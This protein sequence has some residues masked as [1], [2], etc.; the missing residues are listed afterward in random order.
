MKKLLGTLLKTVI[1]LGIGV[2][3]LW[4]FFESMSAE[5]IEQFK[6]TMN[7]INYF[8]IIISLVLGWVALISRAQRWKYV[9]EPLGHSTPLW[10]RY[11]AISIGYL[12]NLTI[13]RSGEASRSAMLMRSD[14]VPFSKSFGTIV[15]ERAVDLVVLGGITLFTIYIGGADFTEIWNEMIAKFQGSDAPQDASSFPWKYLVLALVGIGAVFMLYKIQKSPEFKQKFVDFAKGIWAGLMAIFKSK[16]P[17]GY[18][19]H[20]AIIWSCYVL[21]VYFPFLSLESTA[22]LPLKAIMITFFVGTIG[23]LVTNG[24]IGIYPLMVGVVIGYY[25][26]ADF[27]E[28]AAGIGN[29]LGLIIWSCQTLMIVVLGIL[30][31]FL[32]PKKYTK[33][34]VDPV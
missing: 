2:Y 16:S 30:S 10:N 34:N 3:L 11:H 21:M 7:E 23:I 1:P 25:L 33:G 6:Q 22:D 29:A 4:Y 31:F 27:G 12:M 24:G 8:Y 9:L 17:M 14:N 5:T 18:L 28:Q 19:L 20:T 15:A 26:Q 13:P 32:I